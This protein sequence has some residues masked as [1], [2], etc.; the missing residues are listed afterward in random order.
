MRASSALRAVSS[1]LA[2]G[3]PTAA[4]GALK[5]LDAPKRHVLLCANSTVHGGCAH[6]RRDATRPPRL[7]HT[8]CR[9]YLGHCGDEVTSFLNRAGAKRVLFIPWALKDWDKYFANPA[10]I[11]YGADGQPKDHTGRPQ[12]SVCFT[13]PVPLASHGRH[14]GPF[15]R[16]GLRVQLHS[17]RG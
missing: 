8:R 16:A 17:P 7:S 2:A 6:P 10:S 15:A 12:A 5:A 13:A 1:A 4:S 11:E 9:T 14:T 3:P